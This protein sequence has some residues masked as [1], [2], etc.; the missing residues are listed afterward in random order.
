[1]NDDPE[2]CAIGAAVANTA[3]NYPT[4]ADMLVSFAIACLY[5]SV[6]GWIA[7]LVLP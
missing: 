4:V 3:I 7:F 6:V 1:M 2:I 5:I